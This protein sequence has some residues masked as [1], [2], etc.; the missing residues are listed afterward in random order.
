MGQGPPKRG[1]AA[2]PG[3]ANETYR[4]PRARTQK[5]SDAASDKKRLKK[6]GAPQLR[7]YMNFTA[8][9]QEHLLIRINEP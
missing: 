7:I 9:E 4:G 6:R 5:T 8:F 1:V 3:L 2:P